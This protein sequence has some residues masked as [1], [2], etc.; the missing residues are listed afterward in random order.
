MQQGLRERSVTLLNNIAVVH[1]IVVNFQQ[2]A[3]DDYKLT[4][5][6]IDVH[7]V[8]EHSSMKWHTQSIAVMRLYQEP[9]KSQM[10]KVLL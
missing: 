3:A 2:G 1:C 6:Y 4:C 5:K 10:S 7:D 8:S 9:S